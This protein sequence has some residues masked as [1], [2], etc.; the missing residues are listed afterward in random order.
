MRHGIIAIIFGLVFLILDVAV[1]TRLTWL[2][3]RNLDLLPDTV[4]LLAIALGSLPFVRYAWK[5]GAASVIAVVLAASYTLGFWGVT[6][7]MRDWLAAALETG[8]IFLMLGAVADFADVGDVA[9][10]VRLA[11]GVQVFLLVAGLVYGAMV[12]LLALPPAPVIDVARLSLLNQTGLYAL[13]GL[14]GAAVVSVMLPFVS[15]RRYL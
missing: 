1:G 11:K 5:F 3:G 12:M 2:S 9:S 8:L 10:V 6:F 15:I 4:G 14:L 13:L 7:Y